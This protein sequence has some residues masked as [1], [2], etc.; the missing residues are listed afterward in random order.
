LTPFVA[1]GIDYLEKPIN[2]ERLERSVCEALDWSSARR[3][4]VA[5][6]AALSPRERDVLQLLVRGMSN[7]AIANKLQISARTVEDH[8]ARIG[9]KTGAH[10]LEQ[11]IRLTVIDHNNRAILV[12]SSLSVENPDMTDQLTN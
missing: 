8:R 5:Q 6:L 4:I 3:R 10:N 9:I 11:M 1:G 7:K 12:Q 2:E